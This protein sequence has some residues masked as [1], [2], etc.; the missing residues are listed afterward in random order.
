LASSLK[1]A[2]RCP[3]SGCWLL[4]LSVVAGHSSWSPRADD[5][6]SSHGKLAAGLRTGISSAIKSS[7]VIRFRV[8]RRRGGAR[9][10]VCIDAKSISDRVFFIRRD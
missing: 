8:A 9:F 3:V 1:L 10:A 4:V 7:A 6:S 2:A 5:G